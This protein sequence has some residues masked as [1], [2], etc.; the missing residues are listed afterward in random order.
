MDLSANITGISY[1]PYLCSELESFAFADLEQALA[2]PTF[3]LDIDH[4]NRVAV[5]RWVSPKRTRSY[6]YARVYNTLGFSGKKITVIPVLK[7]EGKVGTSGDRD[8]LQWD[9]IS[10]MS[11][12]GVYV[13]IANYVDADNSTTY[14]GKITN[15]RFDVQY[16]KNQ[17]IEILSYQSSALHWNLAQ[18]DKVGEIAQKALESYTDISNR[19]N[20][21]MHSSVTAKRRIARLQESRQSFMETSREL[22][23]KAQQLETVTLQ[24]KEQVSGTKGSITI[25]NYLGGHYYLTLDEV[26]ITGQDIRLIEAKHSSRNMLPSETDI[27]DALIKMFLF[28]NLEDV[29]FEGRTYNPIPTMKL[30]GGKPFNPD[31]L[32][33]AQKRFW[34]TLNQKEAQNGFVIRVG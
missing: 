8:Y 4:M 7:D 3:I 5:S 26:E 34:D 1:T 14:P 20:V 30:T 9:T 31:A 22:A 28:T 23:E 24:P 2:N 27:K 21:E 13:I 29:K 19:L 10:M 12:L 32:R 17:I 25:Q 15:Q 11:L 33:P 16:V 6:P 18:A